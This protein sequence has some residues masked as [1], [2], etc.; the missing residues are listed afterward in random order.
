MTNGFYKHFL[1]FLEKFQLRFVPVDIYLLQVELAE[2]ILCVHSFVH[3]TKLIRTHGISSRSCLQLQSTHSSHI[4][5][6][7]RVMVVSISEIIN[8]RRKNK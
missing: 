6:M 5:Q 2:I 7:W 3:W 1:C 8:V 4:F